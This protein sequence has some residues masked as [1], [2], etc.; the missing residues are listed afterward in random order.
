MEFDPLL[1]TQ[2]GR[3]TS[4]VFMWI[5]ERAFSAL[6]REVVAVWLTNLLAQ[7][8][9]WSCKAQCMNGIGRP[10]FQQ[11]VVA[12]RQATAVWLTE[13]GLLRLLG[14]WLRV[15]R[16]LPPDDAANEVRALVCAP[17]DTKACRKHGSLEQGFAG[18]LSRTEQP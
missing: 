14:S 8:R 16:T 13:M 18:L 11:A 6:W 10:S 15:L 3:L 12:V 1:A 7:C 17:V 4:A 2:Q 9:T 5:M